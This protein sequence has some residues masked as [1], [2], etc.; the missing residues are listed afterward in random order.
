MATQLTIVNNV[1]RELREDTVTS[2]ADTDYSVLVATF[3]NRAL[4]WAQDAY[5][6][7]SVYIT[8]V[9]DT[10]PADGSTVTIDVT[11]TNDKSVLMRDVDA[12][13]LPAVYDI[14]TG[15]LGQVIDYPHQ[16][17]LKARALNTS[18]LTDTDP[19]VF[20]ITT[21]SDGRGFTMN[22]PYAV[23]SGATARNW[24]AYWYIPQAKL[25]IDGTDD[26][27]GITL[28]ARPLELFAIY[29]A[30]NERGE[31]MGQPGGLAMTAATN[32]LGGAIERDPQ[33]L[34][35]GKGARYNINNNE[36]L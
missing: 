17:V 7:W 34:N 25:A 26:A 29:L 24:R 2:V 18:G 31:E 13:W 15:E 8:E 9:D 12:D 20:S 36:S 4:E 1:L 35:R 33:F 30:L 28:P 27:T 22:I 5:D 16:D 10:W 14:T 19:R 11:E 3:V 21:D 6:E 32:A 23:T